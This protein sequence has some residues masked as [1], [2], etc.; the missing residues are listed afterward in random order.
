MRRWT[1][2][3]PRPTPGCRR[4]PISPASRSSPPGPA[5]TSPPVHCSPGDSARARRCRR[6]S[7]CSRCPSPSSRSWPQPSGA[8]PS[9]AEA[10][11]SGPLLAPGLIA[12]DN[13]VFPTPLDG[14]LD[15]A[16][17]GSGGATSNGRAAGFDGLVHGTFTLE[18]TAGAPRLGGSVV[19]GSLGQGGQVLGEGR[20]TWQYQDRRHAF[21]GDPH[22]ALGRLAARQGHGDDWTSPS[23]RSNGAGALQ[24]P[25]LRR[26]LRAGLLAGVPLRRG[27]PRPPGGRDAGRTRP[28]DRRARGARRRR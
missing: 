22:L 2:S 20:A 10:Q 27:L 26:G 8:L 1:S 13:P 5:P 6:G 15:A 17:G 25:A 7:I 9:P 23:P 24:D 19:L 4:R 18:G 12:L 3:P 11:G 21:D 14:W 16:M 28:P